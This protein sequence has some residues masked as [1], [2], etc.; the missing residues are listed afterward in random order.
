MKNFIKI[1]FENK[2]LKRKLEK[3]EKDLKRQK[4][5]Y[6]NLS[7]NR[8]HFQAGCEYCVHYLPSDNNEYGCDLWQKRHCT[9]FKRKDNPISLED[10][11]A[12]Q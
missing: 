3:C 8:R 10:E 2:K 1:Y 4:E 12:D 9:G 7:W 6:D 11:K 5:E